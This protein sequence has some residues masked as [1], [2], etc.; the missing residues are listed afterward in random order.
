MKTVS[1]AQLPPHCTKFSLRVHQRNSKKYFLIFAMLIC[2][3]NLLSFFEQLKLAFS[4]TNPTQTQA[5]SQVV[6]F[7]RISA[8]PLSPPSPL[9]LLFSRHANFS[10]HAIFWFPSPIAVVV[11]A[12]FARIFLFQLKFLMPNRVQVFVSCS[13]PSIPPDRMI[14]SAAPLSQPG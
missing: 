3:V 12:C 6:P 14:P 2:D 9:L 1:K 5:A 8:P 10:C 13:R 4:L 7:S 11:I